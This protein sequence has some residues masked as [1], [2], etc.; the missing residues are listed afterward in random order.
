MWPWSNYPPYITGGAYLMDKTAVAPL[1]AAAQTIPYLHIEDIYLS[2]LCARKAG[3]ELLVS[4]RMLSLISDEVSYDLMEEAW[5]IN[6]TVMWLTSSDLEMISSHLAVEYYFNFKISKNLKKLL[7]SRQ[8]KSFFPKI[9]WT[10]LQFQMT[11][12]EL[13]KANEIEY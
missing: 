4:Y 3:V 7:S 11:L 13:E 8:R 1:L 9:K 6:N 12:D 2:G 10:V 5:L